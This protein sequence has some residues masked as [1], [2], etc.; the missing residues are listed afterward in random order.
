[1]MGEG[2]MGGPGMMGPGMMGPMMRIPEVMGT[3]M[4]IHGEV[5]TLMGEMMQKYGIEQMTPE[6]R[7]QM[8]WEILEQMGEIFTRRGKAMKERAK[9]G[10][11]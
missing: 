3:M 11:K 10:G 9:A 8:K 5:M 6:R 2:S 4:S 7:Q 1:M